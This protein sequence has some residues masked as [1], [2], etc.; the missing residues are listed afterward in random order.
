MFSYEDKLNLN[1]KLKNIKNKKI[2]K[3]IFFLLKDEIED[4]MLQNNNGIFFNLVDLSEDKLCE[5][6]NYLNNLTDSD[7]VSIK[8][9]TY[10]SESNITDLKLSNKER[11]IFKKITDN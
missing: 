2:Y 7:T 3:E 10:S 11:T 8:Y 5:L 4:I 1:N 6:D 9:N